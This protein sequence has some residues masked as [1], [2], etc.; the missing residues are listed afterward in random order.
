M[1]HSTN[2]AINAIDSELHSLV[3]N[4]NILDAVKPLD[5]LEDK[6]TFFAN[7]F[8]AAHRSYTKP[9]ISTPLH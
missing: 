8:S 3:S 9:T 7:N 4:I 6:E 2:P 1:Q 5:F